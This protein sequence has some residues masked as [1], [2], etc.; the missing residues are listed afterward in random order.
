MIKRYAE[1]NQA[2]CVSCG[3][4]TKECPR[5]AITIFHGRFAVVEKAKCVGC[6][7]CARTCPAGCIE[8]R[9]DEL[10]AQ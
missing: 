3:A 10:N 5:E 2:R 4:C 6:G 1:V 8:I 9:S 7:L